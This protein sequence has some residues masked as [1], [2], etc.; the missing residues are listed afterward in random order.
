M[1]DARRRDLERD[2]AAGDE[3]AAARA[4]VERQRAGDLELRRLEL[5]S[6]L[7]DDDCARAL[8]LLGRQVE[9]PPDPEAWV[10]GMPGHGME[11]NVRVLLAAVRP[12]LPALALWSPEVAWDVLRDT[13]E[14]WLADA[15]PGVLPSLVQ[16]TAALGDT[17]SYAGDAAPAGAEQA[18]LSLEPLRAALR[19]VLPEGCE[20]PELPPAAPWQDPGHESRF[21]LE[22]SDARS[23]LFLFSDVFDEAFSDETTKNALESVVREYGGRYG[24]YLTQWARNCAFDHAA[25]RAVV[26]RTAYQTLGETIRAEVL[27]WCRADAT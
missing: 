11:A 23:A 24:V 17:P 27:P 10:E 19:E 26:W 3:L 4:L 6:Y 16:L 15:D 1:A 20:L 13:T 22:P 14:A 7:G 25:V 9:R 5:G 18:A 8:G 21:P 12:S 2:A